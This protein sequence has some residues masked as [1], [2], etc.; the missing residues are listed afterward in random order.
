MYKVSNTNLSDIEGE[1]DKK[2]KNSPS[3]SPAFVNNSQ[4]KI[5]GRLRP[6]VDISR[7][8]DG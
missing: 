1:N 6:S 4:V 3:P 7:E 2:R 8:L 5:S